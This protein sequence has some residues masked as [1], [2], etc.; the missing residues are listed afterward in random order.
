MIKQTIEHKAIGQQ[1]GTTPSKYENAFHPLRGIELAGQQ[2]G[3]AQQQ[4][5][6]TLQE[7]TAA[8][9][10]AVVYTHETTCAMERAYD[11]LLTMSECI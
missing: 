7:I 2:E 3:T 5:A 1:Y 6:N 9:F 10:L 8:F 11:M 4:Q